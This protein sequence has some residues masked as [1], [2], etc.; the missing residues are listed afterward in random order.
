MKAIIT[1]PLTPLL[2]KRGEFVKSEKMCLK[3]FFI[4]IYCG[5]DKEKFLFDKKFSMLNDQ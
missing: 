5:K 1:S 2:T 4:D 3:N